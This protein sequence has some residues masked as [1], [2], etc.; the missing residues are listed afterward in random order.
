[1][2]VM[3]AA[4]VQVQ[5]AQQGSEKVVCAAQE[6]HSTAADAASMQ[7]ACCTDSAEPALNG[8]SAALANRSDL[9]GLLNGCR[10][11]RAMCL[12]SQC[13]ALAAAGVAPILLSL[14]TGTQAT[15]V[16]GVSSQLKL[17]V[18]EGFCFQLEI[19]CV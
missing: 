1:M 19:T 14:L 3:I 16:W 12:A 13:Q 11:V 9:H 17:P 18:C 15:G 2:L 5:Q 4:C 7:A 8:Q 10:M 6:A